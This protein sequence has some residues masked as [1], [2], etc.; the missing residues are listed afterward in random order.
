MNPQHLIKIMNVEFFPQILLFERYFQQQQKYNIYL[1]QIQN[2][3]FFLNLYYYSSIII[4]L[5]YIHLTLH[6]SDFISN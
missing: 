6:I 2:T 1:I 3:H 4:I 5:T